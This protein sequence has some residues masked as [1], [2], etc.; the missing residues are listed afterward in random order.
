MDSTDLIALQTRARRSYERGRL[1]SGLSRAA[2]A[3]PALGFSLFTSSTL[4]TSVAIGSLLVLGV[5]AL[6]WVGNAYGRAIGPGLLAGTAPLVLPLLLRG[7][8]HTCIGGVC[9]STC[10]LGCI[11]GGL[12]AGA[13]VG[14]ISTRERDSRWAF[15]S[16]ATLLSG[17]T[18]CLG[19]AVVGSAGTVGMLL[20]VIA[21]SLPVSLVLRTRPG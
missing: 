5:I 14:W 16:A 18:G 1:I 11:G 3:V 17:I 6:H 8:G 19:C 21:S 12:T 15:L 10:M 7:T 13:L 4:Q 9:W 20:A 2:L